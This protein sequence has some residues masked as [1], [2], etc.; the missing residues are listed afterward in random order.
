MAIVSSLGAISKTH[1]F[2]IH[3]LAFLALHVTV[4]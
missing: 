3:P 4:P 2:S 1:G